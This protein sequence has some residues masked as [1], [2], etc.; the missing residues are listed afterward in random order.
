MRRYTPSLNSLAAF[1]KD[2]DGRRIDQDDIWAWAEHRR[3]VDGIA[4]ATVNR[5]DLVAA[6]SVFTF[7]TTRDGKRLRADN[8]VAGV[9]LIEPK[10]KATREPFFKAPEVKEILTLSRSVQM[11]GAHVR[12]AASRRWVP[13]ICAYSGA[14]VQEPCWLKKKDIWRDESGLNRSSQHPFAGGCN[15]NAKAAF[16]S[17]RTS[18]IAV[19][20]PPITRR[21]R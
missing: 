11:R 18:A 2:K 6:A 19:S 13:W 16:Q 17:V 1:L 8:P 14:R 10:K 5:N 7:A 9:R 3:D 20:W 4:P 21:A 15:E 12:Q